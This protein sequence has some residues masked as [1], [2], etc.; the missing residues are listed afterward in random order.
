MEVGVNW[1]VCFNGRIVTMTRTKLEA[2][3]W[4]KFRAAHGTKLQHT[5][6]RIVDINVSVVA[7]DE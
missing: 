7:A 1:A 2:K 3:Q 4:I 5:I 6:R